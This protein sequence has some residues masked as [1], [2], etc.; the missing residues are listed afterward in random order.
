M[1]N[2]NIACHL[3]QEKN[4][5]YLVNQHKHTIE[6]NGKLAGLQITSDKYSFLQFKV[7]ADYNLGENSLANAGDF[8]FGTGYNAR[9]TMSQYEDFGKNKIY[10]DGNP[11]TPPSYF[12]DSDFAK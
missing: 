12:D 5:S 7:K 10:Q 3:K 9:N 1:W 11:W 6:F 8:A 4:M 2:F